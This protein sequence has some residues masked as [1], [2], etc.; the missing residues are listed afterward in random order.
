MLRLRPDGVLREAVWVG[1]PDGG[2]GY[3]VITSSI[4]QTDGCVV[5]HDSTG[6]RWAAGDYLLR[7]A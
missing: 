2:G 5:Y 4:L 1:G 6:E 3:T 7:R